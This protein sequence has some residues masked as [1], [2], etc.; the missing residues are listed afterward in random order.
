[1]TWYNLVD[2]T[3]GALVS[4]SAAPITPQAGRVVVETPTRDGIW[5]T[6][7]REYDPRPEVRII[8]KLDFMELFTST[9]LESI[10]TSTNAKVQVFVKKLEMA[11]SVDLRSERMATAVNGME[12]L[13]LIGP[14]RA[15]EV[16]SA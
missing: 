7:T 4:D 5:N 11:A 10:V 13:G 6:S 12:T 2:D 9:E 14:G 3:T 8:D 15:A 1:M 16:L